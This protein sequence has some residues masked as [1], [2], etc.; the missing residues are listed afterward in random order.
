MDMETIR[1]TIAGYMQY[2]KQDRVERFRHLN[3]FAKKGQ[4]V[5]AGSSLM[6]Q[7][8]VNELL[9][10]L[11]LP[12]CIYN[13]GVGGFTTTE[14]AEVLHECVIDLEPSVLFIN[15]GTNDMNGDDYEEEVM[16]SNYRDIISRIQEALPEVRIFT[17]AYYPVNGEVGKRNPMTAHT[18]ECRTNE[19][20]KAANEAVKRMSEEMGLT[21]IDANEGLTDENGNLLEEITVDGMHMYGDGYRIVLDN[22]LP[23]LKSL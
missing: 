6:E 4:I 15:I 23:V 7:F 16:I 17:M 13:R 12:Y 14:M 2:Q 11:D 1:K 22:L 21:Y 3:L 18:Y 19:R 9:M 10:D 20:I 8:P 5:F